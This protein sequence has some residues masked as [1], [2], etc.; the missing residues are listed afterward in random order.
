[1]RSPFKS[2][3]IAFALAAATSAT[4]AAHEYKFGALV[5]DHP[6]SRATPQGAKVAAGYVAIRNTGATPDRLVRATAEVAGRVE[7]HTMS[8]TNGVMQMRELESGVDLRP[9]AT[10]TL[11]PGGSHM[12]MIDLKRPLKQGETIAGTLVFEKAG[13]VP[14]EFKVEGIGSRGPDHGDHP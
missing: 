9:G 6:W 2:A 4:A 10:T 1:M 5:I 12:M 13:E 8:V 11:E 7:L 14:I 3:V